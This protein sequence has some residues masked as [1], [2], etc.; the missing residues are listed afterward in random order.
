LSSKIWQEMP[1]PKISI[2]I[3]CYNKSDTIGDCV[4]SVLRQKVESFEVI[5]VD[6]GSTDG[7]LRIV[8]TLGSHGALRILNQEHT[9]ISA[10]KNRG[11]EASIADILLFIDG[12]CVLEDGSLTELAR[13]FAE[14]PVDCVGGEVRATNS[15]NLIAKAVEYM[16]NEVERKWPFG[17]N[18]AYTRS[19]LETVGLFDERMKTGE[20]AELYV[21]AMKLGFKSVINRRIIARTKNPDTLAG[22][23]RQRIKW[24]RGFCQL[25]EKHPETFTMKIKAC[26]FWI[27]AMLLSPLLALVDIRLVWAP[28]ILV[29]YNLIR[30][31]PGTIA[32]YRG[33]GDAK[34]CVTILFLRFFNALAYVLGW[35]HWRF[36]ELVHKVRRLEPFLLATA[37]R[38]LSFFIDLPT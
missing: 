10:T 2:V 29:I 12:D 14:E 37:S 27:V 15:F 8:E 26:F 34:H 31:M 11:V 9:G 36:L 23:L 30:F 13:S 1:Q 17:A 35:S 22:F 16:Q 19:A 5:V 25:T 4:K 28:P 6:D 20:D 21:R 18:V 3:S 33:T 24:G 38:K 7:S 32:I